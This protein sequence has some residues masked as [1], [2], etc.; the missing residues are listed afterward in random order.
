MISHVYAPLHA[1]VRT[2][3]LRSWNSVM[4]KKQKLLA[5]H[6]ESVSCR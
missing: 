4:M 2:S 6:S 3:C 5:D 1:T